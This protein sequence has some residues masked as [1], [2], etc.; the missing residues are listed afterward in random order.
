MRTKIE[1]ND[2]YQLGIKFGCSVTE[3]IQLLKLA[4]QLQLNVIGAR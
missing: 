3:A 1:T 2:S 4:K